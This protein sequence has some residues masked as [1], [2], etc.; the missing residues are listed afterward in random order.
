MFFVA[1]SKFQRINFNKTSGL[2]S[3]FVIIRTS[4][5]FALCHQYD[6]HPHIRL[7]D[8]LIPL[9]PYPTILR[10]TFDSTFSFSRHIQNPECAHRDQLGSAKRDP[11]LHLQ[12]PDLVGRLLCNLS[13]VSKNVP[14]EHPKTTDNSER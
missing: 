11:G 6:H 2:T 10:V 8:T 12:S 14:S 1:A 13:L 4:R 9:Q 5:P 7:G 3:L